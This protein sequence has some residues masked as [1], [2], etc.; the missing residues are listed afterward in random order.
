MRQYGWSCRALILKGRA[1][2][3][4]TTLLKAVAKSLKIN[5]FE[6]ASDLDQLLMMRERKIH[7]FIHSMFF[8]IS[9]DILPA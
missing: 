7:S 4:K 8:E 5:W 3:G 2:V 1:G 6:Y 9:A